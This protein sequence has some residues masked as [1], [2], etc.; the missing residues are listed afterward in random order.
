MLMLLQLERL[1]ILEEL[2]DVLNQ[3]GWEFTMLRV[4]FLTMLK[5]VIV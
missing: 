5:C 2:V 4:K 1:E 3:Q